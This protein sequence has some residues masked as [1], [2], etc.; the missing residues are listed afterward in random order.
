MAAQDLAFE[1]IAGFYFFFRIISLTVNRIFT[2][3]SMGLEM[4]HCSLTELIELIRDR[5][6]DKDRKF[7]E[8]FI[9][10]EPNWT[11]APHSH[12]QDLAAV[13]WKLKNISE[14]DVSKRTEFARKLDK[15]MTS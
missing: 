10:G 8:S 2:D 3:S 11:L 1:F 4:V 12:L 6:T 5:L 13:R 15:A 14:L 9:M 7:L